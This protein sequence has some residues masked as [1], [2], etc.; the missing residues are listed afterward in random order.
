METFLLE[1]SQCE[2]VAFGF[3][4]KYTFRTFDVNP[5]GAGREINKQTDKQIQACSMWCNEMNLS[6]W[7]SARDLHRLCVNALLSDR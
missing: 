4:L 2:R 6:T 5:H 3:G 7:C 1:F